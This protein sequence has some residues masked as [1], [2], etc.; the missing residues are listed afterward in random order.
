M[1]LVFLAELQ[2]LLLV[3]GLM[4][5]KRER[6][7]HQQAESVRT[8][9]AVD[10]CSVLCGAHYCA[11]YTDKSRHDHNFYL[12]VI[13]LLEL[14]LKLDFFVDDFAMVLRLPIDILTYGPIDI[15]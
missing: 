5:R 2:G 15:L 13:Y 8:G 14:K 4:L 11:C 7:A 12:F 9:T 6:K 1:L 3:Q 10:F